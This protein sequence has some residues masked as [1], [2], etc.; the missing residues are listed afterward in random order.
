MILLNN[1]LAT[2]VLICLTGLAGL[3]ILKPRTLVEWLRKMA[4]KSPW[5]NANPFLFRSWYPLFLRVM[6]IGL[7][8]V[9]ALSVMVMTGHGF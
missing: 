4:R 1:I 9:V 3:C 5:F 6:G 2:L 8:M 7:L